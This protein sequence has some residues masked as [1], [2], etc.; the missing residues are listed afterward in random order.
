MKIVPTIPVNVTRT[1]QSA[2][3]QKPVIV[4]NASK[5][6]LLMKMDHVTVMI[7]TLIMFLVHVLH[8][9]AH[10]I[11]S[12]MVALALKN[13]TVST[14]YTTPKKTMK[15]SVSAKTGGQRVTAQS[16]KA[17]VT[18]NV[19]TVMEKVLVTVISALRMQAL[20]TMVTV[21]VMSTGKVT[22]A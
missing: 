21:S 2:T 10:V 4:M 9:L 18:V 16:T 1:A 5:T 8:M 6:R 13:V 3:D 22:A 11:L 14:V 12:A 17:S 19:I 7:T 20:T 15:D